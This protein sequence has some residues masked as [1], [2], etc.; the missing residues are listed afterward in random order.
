H[1]AAAAEDEAVDAV[2]NGDQI[3]FAGR[4]QD[5]D[6]TGTAHGIHI[7]GR[8]HETL[9]LAAVG[10]DADDGGHATDRRMSSQLSAIS[11][12]AES[13]AS[14]LASSTLCSSVKFCGA[15][16]SPKLPRI[17]RASAMSCSLLSR[18]IPS[19]FM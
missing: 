8:Q 2:E 3:C 4:Q 13:S 19:S 11:G 7:G 15:P 10:G 6:G 5:R 1:V 16:S 9:I 18:S 17:S 14:R 12:F